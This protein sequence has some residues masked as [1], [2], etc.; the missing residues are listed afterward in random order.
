MTLFAMAFFGS[1]LLLP[2][3]LQQVRGES[4]LAAGLLIAPQGLGAMLTMPIAGR[5]VDK[6]G[7]GKIV[8]T[9]ITIMV[10]GMAFLTQVKSDTPYAALCA[11]L[12][13]MGL[14]MGCTMM[15]T[16]TAAIQTL[17]HGQVARGSTLMNI[18]NQTAGSIGTAT[19]SVVLTTLLNHRPL[20][21]AAIGSRYSPE[22]AG[23]IPPLISIADSPMP[24][25]LSATP[26]WSRWC[27]YCSR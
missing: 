22:L 17:T 24:H 6:M 5:L 25:R 23:K 26:S 8:L 1:G 7:P 12:F 20:A 19:I 21:G 15:P 11:A 9:G 18:V 4:T 13:V 16:M 10:L 3:Y 14:G 2:S 27:C